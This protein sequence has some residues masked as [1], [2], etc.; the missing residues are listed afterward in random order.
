MPRIDIQLTR[1]TGTARTQKRGFALG[2]VILGML[3]VVG[4]FG[5]TAPAVRPSA[6]LVDAPTRTLR[7]SATPRPTRTPVPTAAERP[8]ATELP[9][10]TP[11]PTL[12]PLPSATPRPPGTGFRGGTDA[13]PL[14]FG[15]DRNRTVDPPWWPCQEGQV[16]GNRNSLLYHVPDGRFYDKTFADVECFASGADASAAGYAASSN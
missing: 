10:W 7:P 2:A 4:R 3:I 16:K 1:S 13:N 6:S 5:G 9:T 12:A 11:R 8:T 14:F 15:E